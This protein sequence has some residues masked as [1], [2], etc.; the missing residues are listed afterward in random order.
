MPLART[1]RSPSGR[2]WSMLRV[3]HLFVR[4]QLSTSIRN[5][6]RKALLRS[7]AEWR[8]DYCFLTGFDLRIR[9]SLH[10]DPA[11]DRLHSAGTGSHFHPIFEVDAV[12]S[13]RG[14]RVPS[15]SETGAEHYCLAGRRHSNVDREQGRR[16]LITRDGVSA[17]NASPAPLAPRS[18]WEVS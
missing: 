14:G 10:S 11:A 5:T 7:S 6:E 18:R 17:W 9:E 8:D 4:Y 1:P 15:A 3:F 2:A 13:S 12:A 16:R